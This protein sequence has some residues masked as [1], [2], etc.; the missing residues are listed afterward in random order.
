MLRYG[1]S[2]S[3]GRNL[4]S[5]QWNLQAVEWENKHDGDAEFMS[6]QR[7]R[8]LGGRHREKLVGRLKKASQLTKGRSL[9]TV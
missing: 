2:A 1:H 3:R 5:W 9:G 7:T 8:E 4:M 6:S